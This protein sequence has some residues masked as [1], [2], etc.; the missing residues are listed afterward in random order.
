MNKILFQAGKVTGLLFGN[1]YTKI[2]VL[3]LGNE[4]I[5]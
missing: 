3:V 4:I 5:Q 1:F 2:Y